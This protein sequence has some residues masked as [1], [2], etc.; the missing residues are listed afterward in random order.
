MFAPQRAQYHATLVTLKEVLGQR[1][2]R[3]TFT[4]NLIYSIPLY[5]TSSVR[6]PCGRIIVFSHYTID[7][8]DE[9]QSIVEA[10]LAKI[11]LAAG[12][13]YSFTRRF[14]SRQLDLIGRH[15]CPHLGVYVNVT[16]MRALIR[17]SISFKQAVSIWTFGKIPHE[18]LGD[19]P[20]NRQEIASYRYTASTTLSLP[21]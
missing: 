12:W 8:Y 5:S 3:P 2:P 20:K 15:I 10:W 17:N 19:Y 4:Y 21:P 18:R 7:P 16:Q 6:H 11:T 1:G 9:V 13:S 14:K